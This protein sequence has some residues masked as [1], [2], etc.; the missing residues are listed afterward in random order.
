[1]TRT[2]EFYEVRMR[3]DMY[4]LSISQSDSESAEKALEAI[5]SAYEYAKTR[6]YDNKDEKYIIVCNQIVKEFD[7]E[8]NFLKEEHSRFVIENV[9][10]SDYVNS[11][12]FVF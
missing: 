6:G 7:E 3:N 12:V 1:M 2:T 10:Y 5:N 8:G 4:G 9:E 11:F